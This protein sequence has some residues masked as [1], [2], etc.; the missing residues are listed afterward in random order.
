MSNSLNLGLPFVEPAQA[1]KHVTVNDALMR[2]DAVVQ[3]AVIDR[4]IA[5]PPGAPA[6]GDRYIV[7]AS[8]T[9][10]WA[11]HEDEVAAYLDG[12]WT[13]F[14]PQEG[15]F[16]FDRAAGVIVTYGGSGWGPMAGTFSAGTAET[17]GIN[18]TADATNRLSVRSA[19]ALFAPDPSGPATGDVR[20]VATKETAGDVVSHLFQNNYLGRAEFGLIGSD[21]FSLKVSADGSAFAQAFVVD[22]TTAQVTFDEE[23]SAAGG[24]VTL[25]GTGASWSNG[26]AVSLGGAG[27]SGSLAVG[28]GALDAA[29]SGVDNV[30]VGDSALGAVTSGGLNVAVGVDAGAAATTASGNTMVGAGAGSAL[31]GG[32]NTGVGRNAFVGA[33]AGVTNSTAVGANATVGGSNQVQLGDSATT[34]YAYGA[35]QDRSDARDKADIRDTVLGLSFIKALRPVDFRW[36]YR[37]DYR[38]ADGG[39]APKDGTRVRERFHH[40]FIAQEVEGVIAASGVDFGGFQDHARAGGRDV[41]TLGYG[42][43]VGPMVKA[44][45][46][47]SAEVEALRTEV[48]RLGMS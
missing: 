6:E 17:L 41:K 13:F 37:E 40:G 23:V 24:L 3:L 27:D 46:E 21:D 35:V 26:L 48:A 47:L 45:Q 12:A 11:G 14:A 34:T 19:Y 39:E 31:T 4:T 33:S 28:V 1:Q 16:A 8:A 20:I 42:E 7:A 5:A 38:D 29:T 15:W 36:D 18:T 9:G 30:A 10:A 22:R 44:I 43:F 2:L 25:S 32:T